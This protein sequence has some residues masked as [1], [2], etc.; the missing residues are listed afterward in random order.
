MDSTNNRIFSF[1]VVCYVQLNNGYRAEERDIASN[2]WVNIDTLTQLWINGNT[3]NIHSPRRLYYYDK[4]VMRCLLELGFLY[5][6]A[7]YWW[8]WRWRHSIYSQYPA[9]ALKW[10][11]PLPLCD[12]FN[13]ATS[14]FFFRS[15]Y[16]M[17]AVHWLYGRAHIFWI[18]CTQIYCLL[19]NPETVFSFRSDWMIVVWS[20]ERDVKCSRWL[21]YFLLH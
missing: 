21:L 17:A 7:A 15:M 6:W 10:R 8:H 4:H 20:R 12:L 18:T 3:S 11:R 16:K 14:F 1:R 9:P 5:I 13:H 19:W 2:L